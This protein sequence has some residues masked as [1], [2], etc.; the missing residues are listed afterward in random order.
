[1]PDYLYSNNLKDVWEAVD[2]I[3]KFKDYKMDNIV[4][5]SSGIP[6]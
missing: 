1:M 3:N 2:N 5:V 6:I 4:L